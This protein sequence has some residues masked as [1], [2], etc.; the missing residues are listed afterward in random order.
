MR[1]ELETHLRDAVDDGKSL[2]S[3]T[4][5]D[6]AT[7]AEEWAREFRAPVEPFDRRAAF[8]PALLGFVTAVL[9]GV[10]SLAIPTSEGSFSCC[11]RRVV[12]TSTSKTGLIFFGITLAVAILA[13]VGSVLLMAG[14]TRTSEF[15]WGIAIPAAVFT[16]GTW[17]AS[18]LLF[19]ALIWARQS[20]RLASR[21]LP[22]A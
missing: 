16:P 2:E 13:L 21:R 20:S 19:I 11:P 12:E 5:E 22:A 9:L 7:F 18:I 4:G 10:A 14:R 6:V 1:S 8:G 17:F 3:V 15:L